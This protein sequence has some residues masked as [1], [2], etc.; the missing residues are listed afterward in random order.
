M[1]LSDWLSQPGRDI[2]FITTTSCAAPS[3]HTAAQK[4]RPKN[5][6]KISGMTKNATTVNGIA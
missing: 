2:G 6:V 4:V 3:G 1:T 5:N